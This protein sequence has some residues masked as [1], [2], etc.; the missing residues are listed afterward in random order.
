MEF[1]VKNVLKNKRQYKV[2]NNLSKMERDAL[3]D[4][5]KDNT[6]IVR[7]ADKGGAIVLQRAS[8]YEM[9][10]ADS[11]MI[12]FFMNSYLLIPLTN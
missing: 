11:W 4:L 3:F 2:Y 12:M 10:F 5:S 8:D 6:V 7:P 9:K 1:E